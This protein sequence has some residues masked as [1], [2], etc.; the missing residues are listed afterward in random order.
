MLWKTIFG[1]DLQGIRS[2]PFLFPGERGHY[3]T[4]LSARK[5]M[6]V[7]TAKSFAIKQIGDRAL[8]P[9]RG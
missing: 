8:A 5:E 3:N 2:I 1:F 6:R 9:H 4:D 7:T